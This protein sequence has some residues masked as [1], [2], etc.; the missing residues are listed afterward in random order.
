MKTIIVGLTIT[1]FRPMNESEFRRMNFDTDQP[2]I[3]SDPNVLELSNG[4]K[5]I[6]CADDRMDLP[7]ALYLMNRRNE[8]LAESMLLVGDDD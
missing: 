4:M 7:G 6:V 3:T 5:L 8:I 2:S 1:N